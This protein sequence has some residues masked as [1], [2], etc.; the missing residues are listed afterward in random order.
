VYRL[1]QTRMRGFLTSVLSDALSTYSAALSR[2][3]ADI[4]Y[5]STCWD[6]PRLYI[7]RGRQTDRQTDRER[8]RERARANERETQR[9][10]EREM[11]SGTWWDMTRLLVLLRTR[12]H[13]RRRTVDSVN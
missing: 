4:L 12:T 6:M 9:Q 5:S 8:E 7:E 10:R 2:V 1:A 3:T 13:V 11:Y